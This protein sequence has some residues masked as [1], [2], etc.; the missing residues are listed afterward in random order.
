MDQYEDYAGTKVTTIKWPA[1]ETEMLAA[2][3]LDNHISGYIKELLEG[4]EVSIKKGHKKLF[5]PL[6]KKPT[7]PLVDE[8]DAVGTNGALRLE[9]ESNDDFR[10]ERSRQ[11]W[12]PR[13]LVP[14]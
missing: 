13:Q 6:I 9:S 1:N 7:Q 2:Q 14:L 11:T 8:E 4:K 12:L 5:I 10:S 3:M